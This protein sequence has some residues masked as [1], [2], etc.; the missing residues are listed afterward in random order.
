M[1]RHACWRAA[2]VPLGVVRRG[3]VCLALCLP[4]CASS[5]PS[6]I[7][8]VTPAPQAAP[9]SPGAASPAFV[10]STEAWTLEGK[11]GQLITTPHYRIF[12]TI[13]KRYVLERLPLFMETAL[14]HYTASLDALPDPRQPLETYLLATRPQWARVTQRVMADEA[15]V[16]LRIQRG[17]FAAGGKAILY[18]IGPRD[19][20]AIAAHE[21]WHQYSQSTFSTPLPT[22]L[23][24]GLATYMEGFRW[25]SGSGPTP[26]FY[27]WANLER[28]EQLRDAAADGKLMALDVILRST[29]QQLLQNDQNAAL[30]Y[31]AQV[32][33]LIHFLNEGEHGAYQS[34]LRTM[35]NDAASG[36]LIEKIRARYGARAASAYALH[37][38]GVDLLELYTAHNATE[39]NA[40]YQAFIASCVR[41]GAKEAVVQG[42]SPVP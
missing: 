4:G 38:A 42:R 5:T 41:V 33:A 35:L 20:F 9:A 40:S 26:V 15:E 39:L 8:E 16:Y 11:T 34:A 21:G 22:S 36:R 7:G 18:D 17:G 25:I 29:P 24:E 31:Y 23:E 1:S 30:N 12:T 19:T 14:H 28:F 37:H 32:W 3:W 2:R 6:Q 10:I 27:P 13:D